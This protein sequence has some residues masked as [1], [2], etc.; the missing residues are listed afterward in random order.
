MSRGTRFLTPFPISFQTSD[1]FSRQNTQEACMSAQRPPRVPSLFFS[2]YLFRQPLMGANNFL[3][4]ISFRLPDKNLR[5]S[6]QPTCSWNKGPIS[7][8]ETSKA[9]LGN[10]VYQKVPSKG[11]LWFWDFQT[12]GSACPSLW[13]ACF[14]SQ[15]LAYCNPVSLVLWKLGWGLEGNPNKVF[16]LQWKLRITN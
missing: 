13:Q 2:R 5:V 6:T 15:S 12:F 14:H 8:L 3:I 11:M 10:A 4:S 9:A 7:S 1:M 16:R